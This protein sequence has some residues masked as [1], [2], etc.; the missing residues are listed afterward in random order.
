MNAYVLHNHFILQNDD[1]RC[2]VLDRQFKQVGSGDSVGG[3]I[4]LARSLDLKRQA[5][6]LLDVADAVQQ[7]QE[8]VEE[9]AD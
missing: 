3:A 4:A 8:P 5:A 6:D 9:P 7:E 2:S 1:G